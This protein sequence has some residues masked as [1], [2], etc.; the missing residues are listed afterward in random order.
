MT[1]A[2]PSG[3]KRQIYCNRQQQI[4]AFAVFTLHLPAWLT[5]FGSVRGAWAQE[6]YRRTTANQV[7]QL[8]TRFIYYYLFFQAPSLFS[9]LKAFVVKQHY[10]NH[11]VFVVLKQ[12]KELTMKQ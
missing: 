12:L 8:Q 4:A 10:R 3:R 9:H 5:R 1:S 11:C 7:T 2:P 6:Y